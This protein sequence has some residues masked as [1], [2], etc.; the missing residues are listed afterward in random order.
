MQIVVAV[1]SNSLYI[2]VLWEIVDSDIL[3]LT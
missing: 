2:T 3:E 1:T